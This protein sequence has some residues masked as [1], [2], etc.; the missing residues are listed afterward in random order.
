[1]EGTD[2]GA[3]A[4]GLSLARRVHHADPVVSTGQGIGDLARVVG[5]SVVDDE[6]PTGQGRLRGET[7][8]EPG[9]VVGFVTRGRD[10][11]VAQTG[12]AHVSNTAAAGV[13]PAVARGRYDCNQTS[14]IRIASR[15]CTRE[16][17]PCSGGGRDP[18]PQRGR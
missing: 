14:R 13:G 1:M 18:R 5:G 6:P 9:E 8:R 7:I 12:I 4:H 2:D 16:S 17:S 10:R 11:D 3:A 15:R